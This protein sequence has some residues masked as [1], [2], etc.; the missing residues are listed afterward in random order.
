MVQLLLQTGRGRGSG[1][2]VD[3][4]GDDNDYTTYTAECGGGD[5]RAVVVPVNVN[6][7]MRD[8]SNALFLVAQ[9]GQAECLKLL[10]DHGAHA[11]QTRA[12]DGATALDMAEQQVGR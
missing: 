7:T 10:L 1:P 8:A 11:R 12:L 5:E 6:A 3:L 9:A 2:K 4:L